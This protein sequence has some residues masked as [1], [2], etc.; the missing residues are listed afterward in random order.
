MEPL[1]EIL[2]NRPD[3]PVRGEG[4]HTA[5][6]DHQESRWTPPSSSP[7]RCYSLYCSSSLDS[8]CRDCA[9]P[10]PW[11]GLSQRSYEQRSGR[12]A[13][14]SVPPTEQHLEDTERVSQE[15]LSV[16]PD[17]APR[18]RDHYEGGT[19]TGQMT[20]DDRRAAQAARRATVTVLGQ[21][22]TA[23]LLRQAQFEAIGKAASAAYAQSIGSVVGAG[24]GYKIG[25]LDQVVR[26]IA[27]AHAQRGLNVMLAPVIDSIARSQQARTATALAGS[28]V[29]TQA[30]QAVA[31]ILRTQ[32]Y[33]RLA[34]GQQVAAAVTNLNFLGQRLSVESTF[35]ATL[36]SRPWLDATSQIREVLRGWSQTT[37]IINGV[38]QI[39][40][41]LARVPLFAALAARR[42][43]LRGDL[44]TV[45]TFIREWLGR[46]PSKPVVEATIT[47]LLEDDWVPDGDLVL[48]EPDDVIAHLRSRTTDQ[49][50]RRYKMIGH[51]Q[52][53]G[54]LITSL[55]RPVRTPSG[56]VVLLADAVASR[57]TVE[58]Q[59]DIAVVED[60]RLRRVLALLHPDEQQVVLTWHEGITWAEAAQEAGFPKEFGVTVRRKRARIRAEVQR[61]LG[62][63]G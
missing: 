50:T 44:A 56:G 19:V 48:V 38:L 26:S 2:S 10:L 53:E 52:I 30:Q 35:A 13:V 47:A 45:L 12:D 42:A 61:R 27:Q 4:P 17:L 62:P 24:G 28:F 60:P 40:R 36:I 16:A 33:A 31:S 54:R 63:T 43:A 51:T 58:D 1:K 6:P 29:E 21:P 3:L 5:A 34:I 59:A 55:D 37:E 39:G 46:T 18:G 8:H 11:S 22:G 20:A 9:T 15:S 7:R 23:R 14:V 32:D 57:Y 41:T 25:V 49:H